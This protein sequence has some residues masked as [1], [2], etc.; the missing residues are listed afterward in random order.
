[1]LSEIQEPLDT[2]IHIQSEH[3]RHILVHL[4]E[5]PLRERR[6]ISNIH[7]SLCRVYHHLSHEPDI[8]REREPACLKPTICINILV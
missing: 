5:D 1:M 8:K 2:P 4:E 7:G 6:V 3:D